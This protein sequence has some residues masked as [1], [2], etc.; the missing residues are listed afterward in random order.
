MSASSRACTPLRISASCAWTVGVLTGIELNVSE[1]AR[2]T[3]VAVRVTTAE[4]CDRRRLQV[5]LASIS[6]L[7]L[8]WREPTFAK[9]KHFRRRYERPEIDSYSSRDL[10]AIHRAVVSR[11]DFRAESLPT[12]GS[13]V[14]STLS[15]VGSLPPYGGGG[16]ARQ[17][18]IVGRG[19]KSAFSYGDSRIA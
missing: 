3:A 9:R 10:H 2:A 19:W 16:L 5:E 6:V 13:S 14:F 7:I 12:L 17:K 18:E 15:L 11:P 4:K 8:F 1:M